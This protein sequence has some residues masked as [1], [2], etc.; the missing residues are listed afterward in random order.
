MGGGDY[1]QNGRQWWIRL[2]EKGGKVHEVPVHHTVDEYLHVFIEA[3]G[4]GGDAKG[5][6]WCSTRGR[7]RL[8]MG[9]AMSSSDVLRMIKSR[10]V[11][12]GLTITA[13]YHMF[14][15]TGMTTY[16]ENGGTVENAQQIAAHE[17]PRTTK[18]YDRRSGAISLDEIESI[19]L[20]STQGRGRYGL[21]VAESVHLILLSKG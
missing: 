8:L 6:L 5:L 17:S 15:A 19:V 12:A 13:R 21:P 10:A 11:M 9:E 4:I 20:C 7:C 2:H 18:L 1:Y 14:R 16:L 3:A